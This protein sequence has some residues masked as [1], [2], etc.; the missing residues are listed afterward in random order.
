MSVITMIVM[1]ISGG[2]LAGS[3]LPP[4]G[5]INP[6]ETTGTLTGIVYPAES[7]AKIVAIHQGVPVDSSLADIR[8]GKFILGGLPY[9]SYEIRVTARVDGY[10]DV[11]LHNVGIA[12]AG[13]T[14]IGRIE[15]PQPVDMSAH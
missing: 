3:I 2:I 8:T 7:R 13:T 15:L 11:M 1:L 6:F 12:P 4:I 5:I 10:D 9:G 14:D